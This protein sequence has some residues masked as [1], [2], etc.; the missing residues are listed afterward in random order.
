[1]REEDTLL[2]ALSPVRDW[3]GVLSF[4]QPR[5]RL[6]L[7]LPGNY[8]R[9]NEW[10]EWFTVK[11]DARY[12]VTI[13]NRRPQVRTG[14]ELAEGLSLDVKSGATLRLKVEPLDASFTR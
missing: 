8:A 7:N 10:S 4:D 9:L 13:G 2:V 12:R 3:K 1:M 5:H 14:A 11:R 6:I